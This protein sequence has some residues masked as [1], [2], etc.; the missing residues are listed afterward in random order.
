MNFFIKISIIFRHDVTN[1]YK[2]ATGE[3]YK[4][5]CYVGVN[6]PCNLMAGFQHGDMLGAYRLGL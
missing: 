2:C 5:H 1:Y 3:I 4:C 6:V